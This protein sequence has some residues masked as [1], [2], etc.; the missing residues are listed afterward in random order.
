MIRLSYTTMATPG[1]GY[2]VALELA[3][4][5]GYQGVDLR[6]S[7]HLG[8]VTPS[9]P[10][11][12]VRR[13]GDE[14]KAMGLA[15]PGLLCYNTL[16]RE[17]PDGWKLF[18][19]N[20][21]HHLHIGQALGVDYIRIFGGRWP[22]EADKRPDV[23]RMAKVLKKILA[24]DASSV[25]IILQN[26]NHSLSALEG[27]GLSEAVNSPRFGLVFSPDHTYIMNDGPVEPLLPKVFPWSREVYV[28]DMHQKDGE[29]HSIFPGGGVVPFAAVIRYF[30]S[31]GYRGFFTFKW[32]KLWT[33]ELADAEDVLPRFIEYMQRI[34]APTGET[35]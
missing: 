3:K 12:E 9:T 15:L 19:D 1:R 28:A 24:D 23:E 5:Y 18:E 16:E 33:P 14:A 30:S 25:G 21:R 6:C 32:E 10:L 8:E 17:A 4:R 7:D 27:V 26:H 34:T 22:A 13:I 11:D 35:P 20:L 31:R 2:R 29:W